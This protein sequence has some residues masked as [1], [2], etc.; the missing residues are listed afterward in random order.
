MLVLRPV[1]KPVIT[2]H[3]AHV[4]LHVCEVDGTR[5]HL[6]LW[7]QWNIRLVVGTNNCLISPRVGIFL[8][9]RSRAFLMS[10]VGWDEVER[11]I[12]S[13]L[14]HVCMRNTT[15]DPHLSPRNTHHHFTVVYSGIVVDYQ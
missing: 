5:N 12:T 13:L 14:L 4:V 1:Q 9:K 6:V 8:A 10:V 11:V 3:S 7:A 2:Q 15:C